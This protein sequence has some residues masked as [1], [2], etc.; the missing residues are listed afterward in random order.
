VAGLAGR[1]TT[2][3]IT[4]R[5]SAIRKASLIHVLEKGRL[6]ESGSWQELAARSGA[7]A[8]LLAAQGVGRDQDAGDSADRRAATSGLAT[9]IHGQ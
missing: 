1:V 6:V 3:I 7:F 8:D 4:H 9:A 5:L 2:V